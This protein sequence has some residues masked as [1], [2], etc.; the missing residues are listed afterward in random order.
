MAPVF[1]GNWFGFGRSSAP[2]GPTGPTEQTPLGHDAS[3]GVIS[4]YT[5]PPG[6]VYRSHTFNSPGNFVV[7]ALSESYPAHVEYVLVGGGGSGGGDRGG[8]GGGGGVRTNSPACEIGGPGQSKDPSTNA[9]VSAQSYAVVIQTGGSTGSFPQPATGPSPTGNSDGTP[10]N[11]AKPAAGNRPH[12]SALGVSV[13]GGGGGGSGGGGGPQG[14]A[15]Q[16]MPGP[17]AGSSGGSVWPNWPPTAGG[18]YGWKGGEG[19][20]GGSLGAGG[21]GG[22]TKEGDK[23]QSNSEGGE[24]GTGAECTMQGPNCE[25]ELGAGGGGGDNG[26]AGGYGGSPT[27]FYPSGWGGA[28]FP[29]PIMTPQGP[30]AIAWAGV[31]G[32]GGGGGGA[33]NNAPV[34]SGGPGASG[35]CIIRYQIQASNNIKYATKATGGQVSLSLIHI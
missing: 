28:G 15:G 34:M 29:D 31:A 22:A 16:S 8:G 18:P 5:T 35:T 20:P 6:A 27:P 23:G 11:P 7:A 12:T 21:G 13:S 1:T 30:N 17:L 2:G 33:N 10:A 3:G 24:G 25:I 4:E 9:P 14:T 19:D 32:S 26:S